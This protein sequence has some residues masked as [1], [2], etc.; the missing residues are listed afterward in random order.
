MKKIVVHVPGNTS[1]LKLEQHPDLA[2]KEGEVLIDVSHSG[3]NF[4]DVCVRMGVYESAWKYV[5]LPITPGFEYAGTVKAIG[6]NTTKFQVGDAVFGITRFGAYTSQLTVPE[7]QVFKIPSSFTPDQAAGF[8]AVFLTA[9]HALFQ[10]TVVH[11][12]SL[13][14]VHSAA[15]GV[16]SALLQLLKIT[17]HK[18]IGVVGSSHKVQ[19]AKDFGADWVI[20]KSKEDLW[21]RVKEIAPDGVDLVLDGNGPA[22][23]KEGFKHLKPVGKMISYGFHSMFSKTNNVLVKYITMG[24]QWLSIPRF[25]PLNLLNQNVSLICFNV[26]FLFDRLDLLEEGMGQMLKWIE[27]GKLRPPQTTIYKIEDVAQAH[28]AIESGKTT[29]KLILQSN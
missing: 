9:Y 28:Q 3:V 18:T 6:P 16:G 13:V 20:D 14:L 27:E 5:G 29:G 8:P 26:S 11:K 19:V 21:A 4:A 1:Q 2:P 23:L 17:G 7:H 22:T 15:G 10:L 12:N 24:L 25:S